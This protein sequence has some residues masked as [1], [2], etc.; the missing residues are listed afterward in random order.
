MAVVYYG[1]YEVDAAHCHIM[2][3]VFVFRHSECRVS[4]WLL[5]P[6]IFWYRM[7][8]AMV[9]MFNRFDT[10]DSVTSTFIINESPVDLNGHIQC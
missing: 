3:L 8:Y 5:S 6:A 7:I 2:C 10:N 1:E 4:F 9:N